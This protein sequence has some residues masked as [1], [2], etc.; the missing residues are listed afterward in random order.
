MKYY[1]MDRDYFHQLRVDHRD[2]LAY[3]RSLT[4][5]AERKAARAEVLDALAAA[6]KINLTPKE[7]STK[8]LYRVDADGV[9]H[10]PIIGQLTPIAEEDVC[11][12]YTAQALTEYGFIVAATQAANAD[13]RVASIDYEVD[14]PG[15]Y[16]SGVE[17]AAQ[18][19][20]S[21][22]VPTRAV[23]GNMAA[24]A[25]YW[26]ASQTDRIVASSPLSR[27]GS[28]G[29]IVEGYNDDRM[30]AE[31]GI[32]HV[33]I[34]SDGAPNKYADTGTEEGR[35]MIKTELNKL[36]AVFVQRVA[37]GRNVSA[38]KVRKDFGQ[39]GVLMA[40]EALKAGM[41][42]AVSASNISR[43]LSNINAQTPAVGGAA[44]AVEQKPGGK[45]KMD[46][47]DE[48]KTQAPT[49][50]AAAKQE[51][52]EAE[53]DRVAKI[54]RFAVNGPG[55]AKVAAEAVASGKSFDEVMPEL[56]AAS[57]RPAGGQ[58]NAPDVRTSTAQATG[59]T[60]E[61][62]AAAAIVGMSLEDYKKYKDKE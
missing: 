57:S 1:L 8:P 49:L 35:A 44:S 42:D 23:V 40:G 38:D 14:S 6:D 30:L 47:L 54:N 33:V 52:V 62:I 61:D 12:G 45:P 29:V 9:A 25:A 16:V 26:L 60:E 50:Y 51:G 59:L 39:G 46:T 56:V 28:I 21:S 58:E 24:S 18:A 20:A 19:M 53:R 48:L 4:G 34:T 5:V 31:A 3:A 7:G 32:D 37:D 27:V 17:E 43:H 55:A 2:I 11:G 15:G 10:I 22:R 36:E 41:I 13:Q